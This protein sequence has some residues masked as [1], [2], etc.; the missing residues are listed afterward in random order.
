MIYALRMWFDQLMV[1]VLCLVPVWI[2]LMG[3]WK[4]KKWTE[5]GNNFYNSSFSPA[6]EKISKEKT[7]A[8]DLPGYVPTTNKS[9]LL[10]GALGIIAVVGF[11]QTANAPGLE[12][13]RKEAI[14]IAENH[15]VEN[16]IQLGDEW[17][18]LALVSPSGPGQQNRFIWQTAGEDT[19]SDLMG[20]YIGTPGMNVRYAKFEGDLNERA[21][22]Y[23]VALDNKGKPLSITHKLP[24][25]QAGN[26]LTEDE[27]KDLVYASINKH[28]SLTP[29][30]I[31]FISAEPSKKPERMDW[32]FVFK[33][34]ASAKLPDGDKRIRVTINGDEIS[35]HNRFVFVPEE[36]DRKEKD[37]QAVLDVASNAMSFL[38]TITV[39]SAVV[40][41]MIHW[42]RKKITTEMVLYVMGSLFILRLVSFINQ[43]PS[44]VA[45]FSTAQPYNNQL[46]ILL[47]G[48]VVG[49][50]LISMIPTAVRTAGIIDINKAPTIAPASS[51]PN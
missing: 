25:N 14:A 33:D 36:W 8:V 32:E 13:N 40:L 48:A 11:N 35:S 28:Y 45:G 18:R 9:I 27:A 24:E 46:G 43:L 15:L 2:I 4:D 1:F 12:I 20:N 31:E 5:L 7:P 6:S 47:A 49:A 10:F 42:T 51:M 17:N 3:R 16:G 23:Q 29:E 37:Q 41:C 50:L 44:I 26:E 30:D 39:L 22:E 21:E 19:Y 34:I 38:L